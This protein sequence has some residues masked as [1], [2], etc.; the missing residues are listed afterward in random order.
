MIWD[1]CLATIGMAK[2]TMGSSLA[3]LLKPEVRKYPNNLFGF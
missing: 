3:N 1:G 2:L